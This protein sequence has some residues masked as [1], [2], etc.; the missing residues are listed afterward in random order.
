MQ[1]IKITAR[2]LDGTF[3]TG[4]SNDSVYGIFQSDESLYTNTGMPYRLTFKVYK[5]GYYANTNTA[6]YDGGIMFDGT[7]QILNGVNGTLN[8]DVIYWTNGDVWN[9]VKDVPQPLFNT[10]QLINKR[11]ETESAWLNRRLNDTYR[12]SWNLYPGEQNDYN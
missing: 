8:G 5:S 3:W 10:Q 1:N 4:N 7:L 2:A 6:T 9:K 12:V 11:D